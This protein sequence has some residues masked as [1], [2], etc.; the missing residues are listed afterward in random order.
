MFCNLAILKCAHGKGHTG[1]MITQGSGLRNNV[2]N[3]GSIVY[4]SN[5]YLLSNYYML[6]TGIQ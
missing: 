1:L 5:R 4:G 3:E 2:P 6:D